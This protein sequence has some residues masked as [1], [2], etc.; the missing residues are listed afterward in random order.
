M[1]KFYVSAILILAPSIATVSDFF[2]VLATIVCLV[3]VDWFEVSTKLG[4]CA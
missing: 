2:M 1:Y 4:V 3:G